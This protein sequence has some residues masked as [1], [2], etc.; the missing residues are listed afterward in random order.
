MNDHSDPAP[1]RDRFALPPEAYLAGNSLGL[2]PLAARD[3]IAR[4]V[5]E[6]AT[7][8]VEGWWEAGWLDAAD[9]LRA[10]LARIVGARPSEIAV[11]N[12][13]SVNLHLLLAALYRP[14]AERFRVVIDADAFPSDAHVV[15]SH[16]RWHGL[17]PA[18]AVRRDPDAID[19]TVAV[20]LLAGVSYL[21]GAA[22]DVAAV[23]A[24]AHD[25]GAVV[26]L[27]LAHAAGNVPLDLRSCDVDAAAWCS[28]KYLNGGPGAPGAIFVNER[29][30]DAPRL[31]GWWGVDPT[32]R[33][34]MEPD[35]VAGPGAAGFALSTPPVL[36]LAPL[37][38]SLALFDEVGFGPLRERSV[39]LTGML[40]TRLAAIGGVELLTPADPARRGCQLSVRVANARVLAGRLRTEHGVICDFREP[41]VLRFAPV[42]LS[43]SYADCAQAAEGLAALLASAGC[44]HQTEDLEQQVRRVRDGDAADIERR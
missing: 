28:Y 10:P 25:V 38:A 22:I 9:D 7:L 15:A 19:E 44:C 3:A 34:R 37:A 2:Q 23:M 39:R 5:D 11:M 16:V 4:R 27:D 29:H 40:E 1:A 14:T 20:V 21:T 13:L 24:A 41:D 18:V 43:T 36:G 6:W 17:D 33:F 26:V 30:H 31:A 32:R 35:F 42:P 12:T 8:A